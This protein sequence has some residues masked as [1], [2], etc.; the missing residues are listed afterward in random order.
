MIIGTN[1]EGQTYYG[2]TPRCFIGLAISDEASKNVPLVY[3]AVGAGRCRNGRLYGRNRHDRVTLGKGSGKAMLSVACWWRVCAGEILDALLSWTY[4][5]R[6]EV[7]TEVRKGR[8]DDPHD[9][10]L[11]F[12]KGIV[13]VL[14]KRKRSLHDS[15]FSMLS[16]VLLACSASSTAPYIS[17]TTCGASLLQ[18]PYL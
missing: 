6:G 13:S 1:R 7:E 11:P 12:L 17:G 14:C 8:P 4:W 10:T 2:M 18:L 9:S 5:V 3:Y 15:Y 16:K